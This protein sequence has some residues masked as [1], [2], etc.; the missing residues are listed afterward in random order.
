MSTWKPT[1]RPP[2]LPRAACTSAQLASVFYACES[3]TSTT[4]E[5]FAWNRA[6][7]NAGC[8]QCLYSTEDEP[9]YG[10]VIYLRNRVRAANIPGCI[11]L[12]E[13]DS[14]PAGCGAELQADFLCED[15]ACMANCTVFEEL[16]KCEVKAGGGVCARYRPGNACGD[17]SMYSKC[18]DHD[19]F[20]D[21][22]VAF[23]RMFCGV[24]AA[25]GGSIPSDVA[26][27]SLHGGASRDGGTIDASL[28]IDR[29]A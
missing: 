23:A 26:S 1:W 3:D 10:P 20:E 29:S 28:G 14:S 9:T 18:L 25:D 16:A 11:A 22:Y 13:N 2:E 27:L 6:P 24:P 5:C 17:P 19:S 7:A 4:A 21:F 12:L 15:E 8:L